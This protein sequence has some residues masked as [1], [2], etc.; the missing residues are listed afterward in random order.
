VNLK[1]FWTEEPNTTTMATPVTVPVSIAPK[2]RT[3]IGLDLSLTAPGWYKSELP[4]GTE[5]HGVWKPPKPEM[6]ELFRLNWIRDKV[7][8]LVRWRDRGVALVI[9]EGFAFAR[10]NQAHQLGGLGYVVRHALWKAQMPWVDVAPAALKKYVTGR[11]NA[12]KDAVMRDVYKR[13]GFEAK[14]NNVADAFGLWKIGCALLDPT[15]AGLTKEQRDVVER[16]RESAR[17]LDSRAHLV[18]G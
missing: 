16:V 17:K 13:W 3:V 18:L 5:E 11:G 15:R 8:D 4:S 1:P 10:P 12:Q 14:D 2:V 7:L 6:G 9:V